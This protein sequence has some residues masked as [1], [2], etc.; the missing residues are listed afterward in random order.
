[1]MS[2]EHIE[3]LIMNKTQPLSDQLVEMADELEELNR[4]INQMIRFGKVS[5]IHSSNKLIKVQHGEKRVTPFIKWF[6]LASGEMNTYR[7]PSKGELALL[8]DIS[9]GASGQYL[10]LCGWES[11]AF[12]F[13]ISN[14]K[15]VVTEFGALKMLWDS[16][17]GELIL[18][19]PKK[20][21]LDTELVEGTGD[22]S[23]AI[24]TMSEDRELYNAHTNHVN[25]T[26]PNMPK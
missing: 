2:Q 3:Q 7:C 8:L 23:D 21:K 24:R 16:E 13:S 9:S 5:E 4:R 20:I 17:E 6:T 26:P 18:S 22:I 25:N 10:A 1:M 19:A 14:P 12:P 11:D 15:Q